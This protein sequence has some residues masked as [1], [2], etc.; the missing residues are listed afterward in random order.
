MPRLVSALSGP[1]H[2]G[3]AVPRRPYAHRSAGSRELISPRSGEERGGSIVLRLPGRVPVQTLLDALRA[4]GT[5][6]D[7]RG[8]ALRLSPGNLTTIEGVVRLETALAG[9]LKGHR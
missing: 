6:A 4:N 7:V 1:W 2:A 3:A 9:A 5:Y 8:T